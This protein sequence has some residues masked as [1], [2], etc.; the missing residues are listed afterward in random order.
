MALLNRYKNKYFSILGDSISTFEGVSL[1]KEGAFYDTFKKLSANVLTVADTWWGQVIDALGGR[2][3]V[4]NSISGSTVTW[5]KDYEYQSYGCSDE[6]TS[7]L[8]DESQVPDVIIVYLGTN[9]WGHGIK[10][11]SESDEKE[12]LSFFECAYLTML[13]KIKSNYPK[14]EIW[15]CTLSTSY[16]SRSKSFEF[17]YYSGGRHLF[18]FCESIR[19]IAKLEDC[20]LIELYKNAKPY[21]TIDGFHPNNEGM[22]N[23]ANNFLANILQ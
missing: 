12:D 17:P 16:C 10:I 20:R 19:K 21:D 8:G 18:E 4:N 1:P 22:K 23:I 15:C 9:D 3:L 5:H 7:A 2:L 14:A 11:V 13:K 6:R